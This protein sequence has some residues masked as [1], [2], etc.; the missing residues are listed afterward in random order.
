MNPSDCLRKTQAYLFV[1]F[2]VDISSINWGVKFKDS[3]L[4]AVAAV[5]VSLSAVKAESLEVVSFFIC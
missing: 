5:L 4:L 2:L 1:S 3:S